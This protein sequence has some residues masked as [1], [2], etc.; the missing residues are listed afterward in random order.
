MLLVSWCL[1]LLAPSTALAANVHGMSCGTE[2]INEGVLSSS[3][4]AQVANA[5]AGVKRQGATVRVAALSSF[6]TAGISDYDHNGRITLGDFLHAV[7]GQCSDWGSSD[8]IFGSSLYVVAVSKQAPATIYLGNGQ[9]WLTS[10]TKTRLQSVGDSML[11]KARQSNDY[12]GALMTGLNGFTSVPASS[13]LVSGGT[14]TN[15]VRVG[16]SS[17]PWGW[18]VFFALLGL[19]AL[20]VAGYFAVRGFFHRRDQVTTKMEAQSGAQTR[21]DMSREETDRSVHELGGDITELKLDV[22]ALPDAVPAAV[23]QALESHMAL[24]DDAYATVLRTWSYVEATQVIAA[25]YREISG[26]VD[27]ARRRYLGPLRRAVNQLTQN[28]AAEVFTQPDPV[29]AAS[30]SSPQP[31]AAPAVGNASGSTPPRSTERPGQQWRIDGAPWSRNSHTQIALDAADSVL[32]QAEPF[33]LQYWP[34]ISKRPK[35]L[36]Q[37]ARA[38]YD[39]AL[40]ARNDLDCIEL[41]RDAEGK[42]RSA[43]STATLQVRRGV[44]YSNY[45]WYK[46][47]WAPWYDY[48]RPIPMLYAYDPLVNLLIWD[49]ALGTFAYRPAETVIVDNYVPETA[50]ETDG[51]PVVEQGYEAQ[52]EDGSVTGPEY[53]PDGQTQQAEDPVVDRGY[54]AEVDQ[55]QSG[56]AQTDPDFGSG[57]QDPAPGDYQSD[58]SSYEPDPSLGSDYGSGDQ[59]G[60]TGYDP[61]S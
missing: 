12:F 53:D 35:D 50:V 14:I 59:G 8:G 3:Q 23:Q 54:E 28:P 57:Q 11:V 27:E 34:L 41:A 18:I 38:E 26:Q 51:D 36:L 10:M 56:G 6:S 29:A 19:V 40:E 31:V 25:R 22:Q 61:G 37:E 49:A 4:Q 5:I 32:R 46:A 42:A 44:N 58:S 43:L 2:L 47:P 13:R 52:V 17:P 30:G 55:D 48:P 60:D 15:T 45:D 9:R 39:E 16:S 21:A 24:L 7:A 33:F 1:L 20:I